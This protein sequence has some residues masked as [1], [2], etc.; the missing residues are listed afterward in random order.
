[1]P[2]SLEDMDHG[3]LYAFAQ[4]AQRKVT[5]FD[6]VTTNPET[7]EIALRALKKVNPNLPIPEID[8]KDAVAA[9]IKIEREAR[10]KLEERLQTD[11][12]RRSIE[13]R[14]ARAVKDYGLNEAD[15][16]AVEKLMID[17]ENPI[18]TYD[19]AARVHLASKQSATPTPAAWTAPTTYEMPEKDIWGPGIGHKAKLDKIA[20]NEAFKAAAEVFGGKVPGLGGARSN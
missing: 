2:K 17:G 13:A 4:A 15:I 9:E 14:K 16:I 5:M 7:R 3:E 1:M 8:A 10:L 20:L 12:I 18:P 6:Q 19:A 11:E